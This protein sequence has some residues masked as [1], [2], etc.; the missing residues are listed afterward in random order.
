VPRRAGP[1]P[2]RPA[3]KDNPPGFLLFA[4]EQFLEGHDLRASYRRPYEPEPEPEVEVKTEPVKS[5]RDEAIDLIKEYAALTGQAPGDI[6][7][8]LR[9]AHLGLHKGISMLRWW[10]A[11]TRAEQNSITNRA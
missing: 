3:G 1:P 2:R 8:D 11:K 5:P 7:A 6:E 9:S 10:I 4:L